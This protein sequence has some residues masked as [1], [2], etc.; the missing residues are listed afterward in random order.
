[1]GDNN[2][3]ERN[4]SGYSCQTKTQEKNKEDHDM[5]KEQYEKYVR[6]VMKKYPEGMTIG[7][8]ILYI[9]NK[10][11]PTDDKNHFRNRRVHIPSGNMISKIL[12]K[13]GAIESGTKMI[14]LPTGG[15]YRAK[16]YKFPRGKK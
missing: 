13:I 10:P 1:M 15:H 7:E 6:E 16:L 8:I 12:R 4:N 5:K 14:K 2:I 3:R 9:K 11:T